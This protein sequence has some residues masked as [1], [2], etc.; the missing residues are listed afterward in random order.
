[1]AS[2]AFYHHR[3]VRHAQV[4]RASVTVADLTIFDL[5][6]SSHPRHS[7]QNL[8]S[9]SCHSP[10]HRP[11]VF[12][13]SAFP[14]S[15]STILVELSEERSVQSELTSPHDLPFSRSARLPHHRY[16]LFALDLPTREYPHLAVSD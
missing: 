13:A 4:I 7:S 15:P 1:M 8:G 3:Y 10:A 6:L 9:V 16:L 12:Q 2:L 5:H 14:R 11:S